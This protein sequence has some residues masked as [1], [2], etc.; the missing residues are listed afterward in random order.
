MKRLEILIAIALLTGC[1]TV[2]SEPPPADPQEVFR[3]QEIELNEAQADATCART[4]LDQGV[5]NWCV[6]RQQLKA[7]QAAQ[8]DR[9]RADQLAEE[10]RRLREG[11]AQRQE[12]REAIDRAFAPWRAPPPG[13]IY[14]P[15]PA[16]RNC[17]SMVNGNMVTTTCN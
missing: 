17:T 2:A 9:A 12:R 13:P 7:D 16:V 1:A 11:R 6:R 10:D 14:T 5:H 4:D 15:P 8:A 3:Q